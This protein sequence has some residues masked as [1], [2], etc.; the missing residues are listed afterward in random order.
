MF[1]V[2]HMILSDKQHGFRPGFLSEMALCRLSSLLSEA[3]RI[4]K[5]SVFVMFDFSRA[6]N[7]LN[8]KVLL[9]A[10]QSSYFSPL[11]MQWFKLYLTGHQ[12][13]IA[14]ANEHSDPRNISTSVPQ[15]SLLGPLRY[16]LYINSLLNLLSH[17]YAV[18][19]ADD[20]TFVCSGD[21][22]AIITK[23][24]ILL[25]SVYTWAVAHKL[26]LNVGTC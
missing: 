16:N 22:K 2:D 4:K 9:S 24:Q 14:Y 10:L 21:V 7:T 17:D 1:L 13:L 6:F 8:F 18:A 25:D 12:L 5:D 3:K 20:I 11:T 23:M 19:Y 15:E 26:R